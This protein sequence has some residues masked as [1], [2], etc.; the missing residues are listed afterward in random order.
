MTKPALW[1]PP[2]F[3]APEGLTAKDQEDQ[4]KAEHPSF[5]V[6]T[7][8]EIP[9]T[10]DDAYRYICEATDYWANQKKLVTN[11]IR[12]YTGTAQTATAHGVPVC[13]RRVYTVPEHVV[14]EFVVDGFW[15]T[16]R[17]KAGKS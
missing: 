7:T 17:S 14:K 11:V 4:L 16:N 10:L 6:N 5:L 3:H 13:K 12:Q 15:P 9:D 8:A 2:Q 1:V